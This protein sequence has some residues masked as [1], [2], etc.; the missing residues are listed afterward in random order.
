M[1]LA[2]LGGRPAGSR[3]DH[4]R[5]PEYGEDDQ[6]AIGRALVRGSYGYGGATIT[7]AE[8]ALADHFGARYAVLMSSATMGLTAL[9]WAVGVRS[10]DAVIQ[11]AYSFSATAQ[12]TLALNARVAFADVRADTLT[13]DPERIDLRGRRRLRAIV[14]VSMHGV[15][16]DVDRWQR[17]ADDAGLPLIFDNA[18]AAGAT[19]RGH[20]AGTTGTGSVLSGNWKKNFPLLQG[21]VVFTQDEEIYRALRTYAHYGQAATPPGRLPSY[22]TPEHGIN[23]APPDMVAALVL[24]QLPKLAATL[25]TTQRNAE[26]LMDGLRGLPG[27]ILPTVPADSQSAWSR[28]RFG[29]DPAALRWR[30]DPRDLRDRL[31][32]VLRAEGL[33]VRS[34]QEWPL[35]AHHAF[36]RGVPYGR[37]RYRDDAP[38]VQRWRA[39]LYPVTDRMLTTSI[40]LADDPHPIWHQPPS[41]IDH[42]V[43]AF[44]K[45]WA[46]MDAVMGA[47]FEITRTAPWPDAV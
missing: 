2:V 22:W 7:E 39:D 36:R 27:L 42:Y 44:G 43:H 18:Q 25:A 45:V 34:W 8:D 29:I 47:P 23:S 15:I 31:V 26:A 4:R 32:T 13:L 33:P 38:T 24:T 40:M 30:G 12:S 46:E 10:R 37:T 28:P 3:R 21:G 1:T 5:W 19:W 17:I 20:T 9:Q 41:V 16:T 35:P 11:P 14:A 6:A